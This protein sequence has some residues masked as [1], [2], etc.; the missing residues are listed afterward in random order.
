MSERLFD[1]YPILIYPCRI[2]DHGRHS[3]QLRPPRKDQMAPGNA[4]W[5][6]FNDLG[7]YGVPKP[8]REKKRFDAVKAMREMEEFTRSVGGYPFLYADTFMSLDEFK[9][10]F[11]LTAYE[12]VRKKY[13]AVG[14]FPHLY[15]KVKPEIDVFA[16]GKDYMDPL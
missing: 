13:H 4:D 5:G 3:G 8:V 14:A 16:V 11:D 12:K 1:T 2:Y 6:M 15:D 10:M 9:E 7:V